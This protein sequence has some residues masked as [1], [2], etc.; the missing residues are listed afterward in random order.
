MKDYKFDNDDT[1]DTTEPTPEEIASPAVD[2]FTE[3]MEEGTDAAVEDI[4][5]AET[6]Q[7]A[8]I[9]TFLQPRQDV[10]GALMLAIGTAMT[11]AMKTIKSRV[12]VREAELALVQVAMNLM[13][14]ELTSCEFDAFLMVQRQ[15][16]DLIAAM[17][18][19]VMELTPSA[20]Q[21]AA[22]ETVTEKVQ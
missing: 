6:E 22:A 2:H 8:K 17:G 7:E 20:A 18:E 21:L 16:L 14:A 12:L 11:A 19:Y 3:L 15:S 9:R 5:A 13:Q 4:A 10:I 1:P